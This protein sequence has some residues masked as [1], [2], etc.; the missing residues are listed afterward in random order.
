MDT[1]FKILTVV[2]VVIA[3][4]AWTKPVP[5]PKTGGSTSDSWTAAGLTSTADVTAGDD[6]IVT[7]GIKVNDASFCLDFYATST[8]TSLKMTASTT[9]TIEGTDGVMVYSYGTCGNI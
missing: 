9:A 4:A 1:L 2:A 3:I 5:V 7:D 6:V 8:A